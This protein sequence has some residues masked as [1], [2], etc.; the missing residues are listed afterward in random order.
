MGYLFAQ[1]GK[2]LGKSDDTVIFGFVAYLAPT[3]MIPVLLVSLCIAPGGQDVPI[4]IR[5][6][7]DVGPGR[8]N[9]E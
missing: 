9:A 2:I 1:F 6:N 8:W 5:A 3:L 4:G 7:P